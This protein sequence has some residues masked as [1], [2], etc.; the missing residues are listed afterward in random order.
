VP[1]ARRS[2]LTLLEA[3]TDGVYFAV[4]EGWGEAD[5]R[6]VV[7]E[8]AAL[9]PPLVRLEFEGRY[10]AM[11]SHEPKNYALLGY[12]GSLLLRGVAFRSSRAEPFGEAFLRS[13]IAK[14]LRGDVG[15]VRD[16]YLATLN[17]LRRRELPTYDV[18]SRVRLTKTPAG[19][20]ETRDS[21]RELSYEAMLASGRTSWS[22]GDRIRVYRTKP[23]FG[24][25]IEEFE[26]DAATIE[27]TDRRGYDVDH[28]ARVLRETFA[29]RLARA[30]TP[31]DYEAVFAD[32]DQMSLFTPPVATIRTI[33]MKAPGSLST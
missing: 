4:P 11:L 22:V 21:R 2:R 28:Y 18:S 7:A 20:L 30:F 3:D 23:G 31:G 24:G 5:E 15:G 10:A 33:L 8:V 16:V 13:S 29:V 25:V 19:Y 27:S 6:R 1:R 17:G 26:D 9:L 14:L 12:D 32:P